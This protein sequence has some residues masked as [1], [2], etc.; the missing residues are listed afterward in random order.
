MGVADIEGVYQHLL[1]LGATAHEAPLNVGGDI[2][3]AM[4][5]DPW[6]NIVGIIYNPHF[7]LG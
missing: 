6:S 2:V 1:T 7:K 4:V 3:V 5:K